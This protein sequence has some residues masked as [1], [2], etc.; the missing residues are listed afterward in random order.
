MIK[1]NLTILSLP[2][3]LLAACSGEDNQAG[4]NNANDHI[5][6]EQMRALNEA[7]AVE[8]RLQDGADRRQQ[9]MEEQSR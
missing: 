9:V 6:K 3:L 1:I 7:K 5:L 4:S 8:Q 2:L